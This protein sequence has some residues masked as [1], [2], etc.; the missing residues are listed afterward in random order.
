MG[1]DALTQNQQRP[2]N[3]SMK[4]YP[5]HGEVCDPKPFLESANWLFAFSHF[6]VV[7]RSNKHR[8]VGSYVHGSW[9]TYILIR[10][11]DK[12]SSMKI[13]SNIDIGNK[14]CI[15]HNLYYYTKEKHLFA[16]IT[17]SKKLKQLI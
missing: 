7:S 10:S 1:G 12:F 16:F 15:L 13:C 6:C 9:A 8:L 17:Y 4:V 2:L 5:L 3:Q 11:H 14:N